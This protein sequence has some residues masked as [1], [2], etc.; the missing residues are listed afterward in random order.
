MNEVYE[1]LKNAELIIW[2]QQKAEDD[3]TEVLYFE[4]AEA[5]F[6][7]IGKAPL[8]QHKLGGGVTKMLD[9]NKYRQYYNG[10]KVKINR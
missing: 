5:S 2:R 8:D 7:S 4:D 1:F 10:K 3:Y 6:S 9:H